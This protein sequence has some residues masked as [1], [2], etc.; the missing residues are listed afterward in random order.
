[1]AELDHN[2]FEWGIF[3]AK[4]GPAQDQCGAI[5]LDFGGLAGPKEPSGAVLP[6]LVI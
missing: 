6:E 5:D 3:L 2:A 4:L 1:L